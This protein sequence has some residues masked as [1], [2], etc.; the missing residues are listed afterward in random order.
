MSEVAHAAG[1]A[2]ARREDASW[3]V[4]ILTVV[5]NRA[6]RLAVVFAGSTATGTALDDTTAA[7]HAVYQVFPSAPP[8]VAA[9]STH[10]LNFSAQLLKRRSKASSLRG[11]WPRS[12]VLYAPLTLHFFFN[13][14][15]VLHLILSAITSDLISR[16]SSSPRSPL[17]C[18]RQP[19]Q[20]ALQD[21]FPRFRSFMAVGV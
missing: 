1:K 19:Q 11:L 17:M 6:R 18:S 8:L 16:G 7:E 3:H 14:V 10:L 12:R 9:L 4:R 5:S 15:L 13:G 20:P 21:A 2:R